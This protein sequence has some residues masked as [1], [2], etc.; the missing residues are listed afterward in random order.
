MDEPEWP[1]GIKPFADQRQVAR[2][3]L[4]KPTGDMLWNWCPGHGK[5]LPATV[6]ACNTWARDSK[7]K[8]DSDQKAFVVVVTA[9]TPLLEQFRDDVKTYYPDVPT[10]VVSGNKRDIDPGIV[11]VRYDLA[12][13]VAQALHERGQRAALVVYDECHHYH[14]AG[15]T[16]WEMCKRLDARADR[17]LFMSATPKPWQREPGNGMSRHVV[18]HKTSVDA[19]RSKPLKIRMCVGVRKNA[20]DANKTESCCN[21]LMETLV[22]EP[23]VRNAIVFCRAV[24][25]DKRGSG[26]TTCAADVKGWGKGLFS[27]F[28]RRKGRLANGIDKL[29]VFVVY[30]EKTPGD[31]GF[32]IGRDGAVARKLQ[33]RW[34]D[35]RKRERGVIKVLLNCNM[36]REGINTPCDLV[37]HADP[38]QSPILIIQRIRCRICKYD[39]EAAYRRIRGSGDKT[40]RCSDPDRCGCPDEAIVLVHVSCELEDYVQQ[41]TVT[42]RTTFLAERLY[43]SKQLKAVL[44]MAELA[45]G[46]P[47][48]LVVNR[49]R[50][51]PLPNGSA[52]DGAVAAALNATESG[53]VTDDAAAGSDVG[54]TEPG[55]VSD[56]AATE[57]CG[58]SDDVVPCDALAGP[59]AAL[60]SCN[61]ALAGS[62]DA[63]SRDD[64]DGSTNAGS[65]N[66]ATGS[67]DA[68]PGTARRDVAPRGSRP[69][70]A[71]RYGVQGMRIE[72]ELE[73]GDLPGETEGHS[74]GQRIRAVTLKATT[75]GASFLTFEA[76]HELVKDRRTAHVA[77]KTEPTITNVRT[78]GTAFIKTYNSK[79]APG[80][81]KLPTNPNEK[82]KDKGWRGWRHFCTGI[83]PVEFL[84]FEAAH[85]LVKDRRTAHVADETERTITNFQTWCKALIK[86]YNSQLK[87]GEPKLHSNPNE[88]YKDTG[89]RGWPHFCTGIVPAELLT[90]EAAHELVKDRRTAHVADKTE[91]AITNF[92]TWGEAFIKTYN[93]KLKPG[94]PKLPSSPDETYKDKG[95]RGWRHF[96]TGIV[97][98]EFLEFEAAHELVKDRRTAHVADKTEPTITCFQ[99][100]GKSFIKTYNSQLKPGEPKLPTKPD[101]KYKGKGWFGWG[102]FCGGPRSLKCPVAYV[103]A[104]VDGPPPPAADVTAELKD[105]VAI[106]AAYRAKKL[107]RIPRWCGKKDAL[108]F[109]TER[110]TTKRA[111]MTKK[112]AE[113]DEKRRK[114]KA[115]KQ[116][117]SSSRKRKRKPEAPTFRPGEIKRRALAKVRTYLAAFRKRC[118]APNRPKRA[119]VAQGRRAEPRRPSSSGETSA[120]VRVSRD[121]IGTDQSRARGTCDERRI[122]DSRACGV[123]DDDDDEEAT[124]VVRP[125]HSRRRIDTDS[126]SDSETDSD[127]DE[128]IPTL[129]RP[130]SGS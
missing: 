90:F 21:E 112:K 24:D 23:K 30:G 17:R 59:G 84:E 86:T 60:A 51:E 38:T 15:A 120:A 12:G 83:V 94:E 8:A 19:G 1:N 91:P 13:R 31:V 29:R 104:T 52:D 75:R 56:D 105:M 46:T 16:W 114:R 122:G 57:P 93:S 87:P 69:S 42:G 96:C 130:L 64:A 97:P 44:D 26:A 66:D 3:F 54:A 125:S 41:D 33:S 78:W 37:M 62:D 34:R 98:V 116:V 70:K 123:D 77:D 61:D 126:E 18:T 48:S 6:V 85:E 82:Y 89:W 92:Q 68:A 110:Y 39:L 28:E 14:P 80:E 117:S 118:V 102:H 103:Q 115:A 124:A 43:Q 95:W 100:W 79:L 7:G 127:F 81:P 111:A 2:E 22:M 9:S 99:T 72:F 129:L 49:E 121:E 5:T 25:P 71:P 63:G 36:A 32:E 35:F 47:I 10:C 76:A 113:A 40:H 74:I 20:S 119:R 108:K 45:H 128:F 106:G 88:K 107:K 73:L 53:G 55:G 65:C 101:K 4:A 50:Q 11:I 109:V 27:A 58:V 67:D